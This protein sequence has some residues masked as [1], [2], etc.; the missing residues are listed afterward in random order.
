VNYRS[1][2]TS[3]IPGSRSHWSHWELNSKPTEALQNLSW[4]AKDKM[5]VFGFK[6]VLWGIMNWNLSPC[7][8]P[9][10]VQS[11]M[12]EGVSIDARH[13]RHDR[14]KSLKTTLAQ[15]KNIANCAL[16]NRS[17]Q[18]APQIPGNTQRQCFPLILIQLHTL[19]TAILGLYMCMKA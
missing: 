17:S 1:P 3:H 13:G 16:E 15:E 9:A 8:P 5:C 4:P 11:V 10:V 7:P 2:P 12:L 6:M 14:M 19:H 18:S